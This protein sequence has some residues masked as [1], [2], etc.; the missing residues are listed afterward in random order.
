MKL[1]NA[2]LLL[3]ICA[4]SIV[5]AC[6]GGGGSHQ[7]ITTSGPNVQ[8]ITVN[9]G[10]NNNYAN[11]A[12][13]SVTVC[14]PNTSNCQTIDNI[15][16]DTGSFGLRIISTELSISLPQQTGTGGNP[17]AECVAFADSYTWG[18]V[19][20][21]D[22]QI[23]G[24]SASS[25][26]V[27]VLSDT[28]YP[29]PS[30]CADLGL[31]SADT[32]QTMNAAGLLGVGFLAQDC[33]TACTVSGSENPGWYYE[34]P[35]SGCVVTS[36]ASSSQVTNPVAMFSTDNNG[37]I[38]ELPAV[39][40]EAPTVTG[41]LVFGIGTQSNNGLGSANVYT[42]Q[43]FAITT[44]FNGT[45]YPG[46]FLDSGSNGIFFLDTAATGFPDCSGFYCPN[47]TQNLSATNV[48]ANGTSESVSFSVA[49]AADLLNNTDTAYTQLAGPNPGEFDWGLSFFYGHNV[50]TAIDGASTP[51]GM[52]PYWAY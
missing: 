12:F 25:V 9:S 32:L 15:L 49:N 43:D 11:G 29:L 47:S 40:I 41:S 1:R 52:G 50:F 22:I 30:G 5:S 7:T 19:Q 45:S 10:P 51:A 3:P 6:G 46:S 2:F 20:T 35:S 28:A 4:L 39:D 13:T 8:T 33:G 31:P 26:P 27:Q 14:V 24:E 21:A 42:Q 23:S 17:V 18:P 16:V 48:G 36:V 38:V 34:C 37:V 44:S